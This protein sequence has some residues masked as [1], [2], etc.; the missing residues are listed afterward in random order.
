[1]HLDIGE[2][3][4]KE[5][6]IFSV[7]LALVA[8]LIAS[9]SQ[10]YV[11]APKVLISDSTKGQAQRWVLTWDNAD[12]RDSAASFL[13]A[14]TARTF[15]DSGLI[16][17]GSRAKLLELLQQ[18]ISPAGSQVLIEPDVWVTAQ[19][20]A[21]DDEFF[22]LQWDM[23]TP[24]ESAYG[25]D[26]P[27]ARDRFIGEPGA[28]ARVAILDT[29]IQYHPDLPSLP[30]TWAGSNKGWDFYDQDSD[31]TDPGDACSS[32]P[33]PSS[34]W[35]GTHVA[36][37][38]AAIANNGIGVAGI[39]PGAD[40][41]YGRVLGECGGYLTDIA[42]AI[43]WAAGLTVAGTSIPVLSPAAKVVNL[44]LGGSGSC[45]SYMQKAITAARNAGT[46]V[47]VA[48]G[49]D[50]SDASNFTPANCN[51]VI[52]VGAT[53][54]TGKRSWYSNYGST[55]EISAPGGD[56][57]VTS[58]TYIHG[59]IISTLNS[60]VTVPGEPIYEWYQ[61]TSMATPHVVG[62]V[63]LML[64]RKPSLTPAQIETAIKSSATPFPAD[65]STNA[66]VNTGLV[67]GAGILNARAAIDAV[68]P[69]T[70][71]AATLTGPASGVVGTASSNFSV[72]PNSYFTG[73]ILI[74]I[75]GGGLNT[76]ITK[77]FT[78]SYVPQTFTITPTTTGQ[79]KLTTTSSPALTN[80]A[81][82][83]YSSN[84]TGLT[85]TFSSPVRA[86]GGF[87]VNVTNFNSAF[88]YSFTSSAGTL[89]KGTANGSTLPLTITKLTN[90]AS[91]TLT[92]STT[93]TGFMPGSASVTAAALPGAPLNAS[94]SSPVR[95]ADGF[96]VNV[97]NY[98][99]NYVFT[100]SITAGKVTAGKVN[101]ATIPLTVTGLNPGQSATV[102]MTTTRDTYSNGVA[103][104]ASSA[105]FAGLKPTLST[106]VATANGFTVNVTNYDKNYVFT[107]TF[108]PAGGA[109]A[110]SV[111]AVNGATLPLTIT[112]LT[113]GQ[114][115][116]IVVTATRAGYTTPAGGRASAAALLAALVPTFSVP[117]KTA[118][119]FTVNMT[120][121]AAGYTFT[122]TTSAGTVSSGNASGKN[123]PLT[124]TG[125]STPGQGA[126]ITVT[127]TRAGYATG[128]A[129]VSGTRL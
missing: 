30:A 4:R 25:I 81:V 42:D 21:V 99:K 76:T 51:G 67:C 77:T 29:G 83:N 28:G 78:N 3:V 12:V 125:L 116:T 45:D 44:S 108:D 53:G 126:I 109:A 10:A 120:N 56:S 34:S 98:D 13:A 121:Y 68:V 57:E 65:D 26:L 14:I 107:P 19:K 7:V 39:A 52:T 93:R 70:A 59:E 17:N 47:V 31:P 15:Q 86:L 27:I 22:P 46:T 112:G 118:T 69:A 97:T 60:G 63:A 90:T 6:K 100:P 71:S 64:S 9:P 5:I 128:S 62:V 20:I 61:G 55:V 89:T 80:P 66:C 85:P 40:L 96:T 129:T 74:A 106:P 101:G 73:S 16:V 2:I 110:V 37:T 87:T 117:V 54:L 127:V 33:Y 43:R 91:A 48:A 113:P 38:I 103:T 123:L 32:D 102:T 8:T 95:T 18:F 119:G 111:G 35:H 50:D 104:V 49:N 23:A 84:N 1:V 41:V 92:A 75:A 24:T 72:A 58:E 115:R 82:V 88:T 114:A 11:G 124:L 122:V 79:V 94:F 36:G 105:L